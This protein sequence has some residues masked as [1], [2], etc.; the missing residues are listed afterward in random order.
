MNIL[1]VGCHPDD[2][3]LGCGGTLAK[4]VAQKNKV[5]MC[6]VASG[7]VG[8]RIIPSDELKTIRKNE[9]IS[10]GNLIGAEVITL[11][12][13][14]LFVRAD[15]MKL[16]QK[17]V[18]VIRFTKPDIIITHPQEDYMDDHEETS[19]LVFEA[20]MAATVNQYHT[21]YEYYPIITPIYYMEPIWG[22]HSLPEEYVDITDYMDMKMQM[23]SQHQ[24]Q[25]KWLMDHD[26][27]DVLENCRIMARFRGIQ[28]G[29]GFA[30]GFTS[31]KKFHKLTTTR[32]LP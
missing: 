28:T 9:A 13:D 2:L 23:M 20:S 18:D 25:V 12:T 6:M 19:R 4:Y 31:S 30:E 21:E 32:Y 26:K 1:A 8:H 17:L 11:D 29:V 15:D 3:E 7:N 10:S 22:V 27:I 5:F 16:R 14:D 24:S